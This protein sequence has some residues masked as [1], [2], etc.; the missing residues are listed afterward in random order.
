MSWISDKLRR[1]DGSSV[2][3]SIDPRT[4][5]LF[6]V[7][8]ALLLLV[9]LVD[10]MAG[11]S[12][13]YA[14][15]GLL[16]NHTGLWRSHRPWAFSF[17]WG[18]S[19]VGEAL[20]VMG[21]MGLAYTG[22]LLGYRTRL[23]QVLSLVAIL[24]LQIRVDI[25]SNGGSFV[26]CIV[27]WWSVFMPLGRRF[28]VDAVLGS[29]ERDRETSSVELNANN[30]LPRDTK[31]FVSLAVLAASLQL[32]VIYCFNVV[33]K[34]GV[35]W[36]E[37]SAIHYLLH[38]TRLVTTVGFWARELPVWLTQ[39]MTYG[40][41]GVEALISLAILSPLARVG[42]RRL[43]VVL[44]LSL[45]GA[46]ALFANLGVFSYV[47]MVFSLL[48]LQPEDWQWLERWAR[49]RESRR[50][51]VFYDADCGIC[52]L[53]IRVLSRLDLFG[54]LRFYPGQDTQLLPQGVTSDLA[55]E[56]LVVSVV[57]EKVVQ[58]AAV[59]ESGSPP[60]EH[61]LHARA[62][63]QV[64]EVLP[65]GWLL[66]KV[67][68]LPG[69]RHIVAALYRRLVAQRADVSSYL[70]LGV[71][72][73]PPLGASTKSLPGGNAAQ[74]ADPLL[75][76]FQQWLQRSGVQLREATIVALLGI[77]IIQVLIEN[78]AIPAM[79]RPKPAS[80]HK[81]AISYTR[82]QQGW[83]MFAPD[84]PQDEVYLIV[85][86]VTQGGRHVDPIAE[87]S[88][89]IRDAK[90]RTMPSVP[91]LS[92]AWVSY[93][94]RIPGDGRHHR[95]LRQWLENYPQRTGNPKDRLVRYEVLTLRRN[96]PPLG[97]NTVQPTRSEIW[98]RG[99][100]KK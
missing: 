72:G 43:A 59:N 48:L 9:N 55:N 3:F 7:A 13:W 1:P 61:W 28:S 75:S 69:P 5:G 42:S 89:V 26:L 40:T 52:F 92:K 24:S 86:A 20:A 30:T 63:G 49:G 80:W 44:I 76:P 35:T 91:H 85:D 39:G 47:M 58:E 95:P 19:S 67:I 16:P 46:I 31:P 10:Q 33:H 12:L 100:E 73:L 82:L 94:Q 62:L 71:C 60:G 36:H 53:T 84:A 4:L 87:A 66:G 78:P 65:L 79:L 18:S 54:R 38:Q 74:F 70:G 8:L 37:G 32:A 98:L 90:S 88:G 2:Y 22:L 56:T 6:R 51:N 97:V 41:L 77:S 57:Q 68:A 99:P 17:L 15:E 27:S 34:T 25:L 21:A 50:R 11:V 23:C 93:M 83:R 81:A 96:S 64:V 29:M 14:N 45:H